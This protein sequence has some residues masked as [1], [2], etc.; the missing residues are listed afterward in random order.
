MCSRPSRRWPTSAPKDLSR[1]DRR[2]AAGA[3]RRPDLRLHRAEPAGAAE[4][5]PLR[6]RPAARPVRA[7]NKEQRSGWLMR[8]E[9]PKVKTSEGYKPMFEFMPVWDF[10]P[11]MSGQDIQ[12]HGRLLHPRGDV[13]LAGTSA[14]RPRGLLR[15]GHPV[16][17]QR[18][19]EGRQLQGP[20]EH[21]TLLRAMGVK[22]NVNEQ[23]ADTQKYEI[24]VWHGPI[25]GDVPAR[26]PAWTSPRTRWQMRS[27]PRCGCSAVTSSS[28]T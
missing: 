14:V 26:R 6:A 3:W 20:M 17:P 12:Q 22:V 13:A 1:P 5:H 25:S 7:R 18:R 9:I 15:H 10:Y 2:P 27:T 11:D 4:R 16:L 19:G 21:E 8:R 24:I 23:K 28:A